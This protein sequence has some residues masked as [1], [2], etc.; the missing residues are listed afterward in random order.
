[1]GL[2]G[3]LLLVCYDQEMKHKPVLFL[4]FDRPLFDTDQFYDWLGADRFSRILDLSAG[5]IEAPDFS[6]MVYPDTIMFLKRAKKTHRLVLLTYTVNT[7]LQRR[8]VRG[9]G[10][11]PFFDDIIMTQNNKGFEAKK[12]LMQMEGSGWPACS[13]MEHVF[14]EDTPKNIDDMKIVN[15]QIKTVRIER[16][17]LTP[18]ESV[19]TTE[20][21]LVVP[22]LSAL[23]VL[24]F[25]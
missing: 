12:Y 1:V 3:G 9:S 7:V 4:D 2:F 14:V 15:P 25:A 24:L 8:K 5:R 23:S 20:P 10:L 17:S 13:E 16:V 18:E 19:H 11:V 21:D 22:S 6:S